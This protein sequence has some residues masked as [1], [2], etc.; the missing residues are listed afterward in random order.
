MLRTTMQHGFDRQDVSAVS[1]VRTLGRTNSGSEMQAQHMNTESP[2]GRILIGTTFTGPLREDGD[3][4]TPNGNTARRRSGGERMKKTRSVH[5]FGSLG[6][7]AEGSRDRNGNV[8]GKRRGSQ[9]AARSVGS[10]RS[11]LSSLGGKSDV[12][13]MDSDDDDDSSLSSFEGGRPKS[14]SSLSSDDDDMELPFD[15]SR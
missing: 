7:A 1:A 5:S 9:S 14:D 4:H 2:P 3:G 12:D 8:D 10:F 6:A 15:N 13:D 11:L